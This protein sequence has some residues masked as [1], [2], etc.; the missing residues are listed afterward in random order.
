MLA[1]TSF[2]TYA[3]I[4]TINAFENFDLE[5]LLIAKSKK[6]ESKKN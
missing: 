5:M 1:T 4:S 3:Y 2:H 6:F